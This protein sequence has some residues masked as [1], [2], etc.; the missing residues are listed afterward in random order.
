[1]IVTGG[2]LEGDREH[3]QGKTGEWG[4]G[5]RIVGG[6]EHITVSN[7]TSSKMWGDG[8]YIDGAKDVRLC[9]VVAD[10]NRRQGLLI[11]RNR[12]QFGV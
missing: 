7:I 10:F 12:H 8:F 2:T 5:I 3:H 4:M 11:I 1:M 9:N 6:A